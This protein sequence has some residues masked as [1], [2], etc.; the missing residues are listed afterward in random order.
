MPEI[1]HEIKWELRIGGAGADDEMAPISVTFE[2]E[3]EPYVPETGPTYDSGGQPSEG[4]YAILL[5]ATTTLKKL[6]DTNMSWLLNVLPEA[7]LTAIAEGLYNDWDAT[8][9][10]SGRPL[11]AD[12]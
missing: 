8:H 10:P 6:G 3:I 12:G 7:E 9:A 1:T 5:A 2:G 11:L 4:G